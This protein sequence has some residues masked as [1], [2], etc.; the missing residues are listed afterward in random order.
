MPGFHQERLREA[1]GLA[2]LWLL[3]MGLAMGRLQ[4]GRLEQNRFSTSLP[5]TA[6][7]LA[8]SDD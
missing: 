1:E 2:D 8:G 3:A 7:S 5:S 4:E 6:L